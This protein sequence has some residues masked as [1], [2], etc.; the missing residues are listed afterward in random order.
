MDE[1]MNGAGWCKTME[2]PFDLA[3]F[4]FEKARENF[5]S[6]LTENQKYY[7]HG[8]NGWLDDFCEREAM[9]LFTYDMLKAGQKQKRSERHSE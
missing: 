5:N 7:G 9:R 6:F 8:V 2:S 4:Y 3:A 1:E